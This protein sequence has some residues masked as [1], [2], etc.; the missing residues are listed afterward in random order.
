M[1]N[2]TKRFLEFNGRTIWFLSIDGQYWIAIKPICEALNVNYDRQYKNLK[3][4]H[5]LSQLYAIQPMVA[6]DNRVRKMVAIPEEYIYGWLFSIN[7]ESQELIQYQKECYHILFDH[8]HGAL[9]AR[10]NTL[11][12]KTLEELEMEQLKRKLEETPEYQRLQEL[13]ASRKKHSKL[14]T[15][16]D[17]ELVKSQLDLWTSND[18][19]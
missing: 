19:E 8:F 17:Q 15:G 3:K 7:S 16:L 2:T 18:S 5:I 4:H 6:E 12:E 9:S 11:R 14:L 13:Q 1:Q 10:A